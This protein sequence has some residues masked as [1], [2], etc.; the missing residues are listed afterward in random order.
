MLGEYEYAHR[1]GV[2]RIAGQSYQSVEIVPRISRK[3][4]KRK[5]FDKGMVIRY[6]H[7]LAQQRLCEAFCSALHFG[8]LTL[9]SFW[10]C[11]IFD[12]FNFPTYANHCV[13]RVS[14][15]GFRESFLDFRSEELS[16]R[17]FLHTWDTEEE[18][19][20]RLGVKRKKSKGLSALSGAA[21]SGVRRLVTPTRLTG[22]R[23]NFG[24]LNFR[25]SRTTLLLPAP[26]MSTGLDESIL[27]SGNDSA[28][29]KMC[30]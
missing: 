3:I 20:P 8:N 24:F 19:G 13:V 25:P 29:H 17:D 9:G 28:P 30:Y 4:C 21:C 27:L 23:V 5:S 1:H 2:C 12:I 18:K 11:I 7:D 22:K 6:I 16:I 14:T 26:I 10:D 15:I